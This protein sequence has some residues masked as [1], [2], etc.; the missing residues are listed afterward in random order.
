MARLAAKVRCN[1]YPLPGAEAE[2]IRSCLTF[3]DQKL[4]A[5]DPAPG[6][7]TR[8]PQSAACDSRVL[9][10]PGGQER[11]AL[12]VLRGRAERTP[13]PDSVSPSLVPGRGGGEM[14]FR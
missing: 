7:D 11:A 10:R 3:P 2:R 14:P 9:G 13:Q 5:L 8:W 4:S 6:K 12:R 1:Y